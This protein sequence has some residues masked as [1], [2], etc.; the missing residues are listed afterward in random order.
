MMG[1]DLMNDMSDAALGAITAH[2]HSPAYPSQKTRISSKLIVPPLT[3]GPALSRR[4]YDDIH[5]ASGPGKEV[6]RTEP[7]Q[8]HHALGTS[9]GA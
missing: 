3:R 4:G 7:I 8:S 6:V 1:G 9:E 2:M 5:P